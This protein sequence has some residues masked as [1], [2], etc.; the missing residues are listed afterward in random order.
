ML[1]Q[2]GKVLVKMKCKHQV[3][4]NF[5]QPHSSIDCS[6]LQRTEFVLRCFIKVGEPP[7]MTWEKRISPNICVLT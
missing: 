3:R 4:G 2:L 7:H 1:L 5:G 6:L